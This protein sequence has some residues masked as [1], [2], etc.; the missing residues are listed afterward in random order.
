MGASAVTLMNGQRVHQAL[1]QVQG[2]EAAR[3]HARSLDIA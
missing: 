1:M 2:E 3:W